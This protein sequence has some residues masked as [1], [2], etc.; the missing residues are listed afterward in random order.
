MTQQTIAFTHHLTRLLPNALEISHAFHSIQP[1]HNLVSD[2]LVKVLRP[3]IVKQADECSASNPD[4]CNNPGVRAGV[5]IPMMLVFS[6]IQGC[7]KYTDNHNNTTAIKENRM[8][9]K[10]RLRA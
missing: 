7:K 5:D 3:Q 6:V 4:E 1:E 2:F 8:K 10:V 9:D